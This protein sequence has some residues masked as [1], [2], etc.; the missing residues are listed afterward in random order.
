MLQGI[1]ALLGPR[2]PPIEEADRPCSPL[3]SKK[4]GRT[5][6]KQQT[7]V[8]VVQTLKAPGCLRFDK[9]VSVRVLGRQNRSPLVTEQGVIISHAQT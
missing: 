1:R 6:H 3:V 4:P 2:S 8:P 9:P 5:G 7:T